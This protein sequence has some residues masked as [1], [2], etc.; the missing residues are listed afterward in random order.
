MDQFVG[1]MKNLYVSLGSHVTPDKML[2][3]NTV[4]YYCAFVFNTRV[5]EIYC[6]LFL[7]VI[8]VMFK[9]DDVVFGQWC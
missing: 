9:N 6:I 2:L 7:L 8:V 4:V 1:L 3:L 5:F